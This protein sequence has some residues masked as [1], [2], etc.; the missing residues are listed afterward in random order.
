MF[1]ESLSEEFTCKYGR[2]Q[3]HVSPAGTS[4]RRYRSRSI[5]S[6]CS[7]WRGSSSQATAASPSGRP[8]ALSA[9]ASARQNAQLSGLAGEERTTRRDSPRRRVDA[10]V[11]DGAG[12]REGVSR[13]LGAHHGSRGGDGEARHRLQGGWRCERRGEPKDSAERQQLHDLQNSREGGVRTRH[14]VVGGELVRQMQR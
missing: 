3:W 12:S 13:H 1:K 6:G 8:L 11:G 7:W 2:A 9:T 4:G 10:C 14:R 5:V